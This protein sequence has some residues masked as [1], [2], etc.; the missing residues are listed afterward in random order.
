MY[1]FLVCFY[2]LDHCFWSHTDRYGMMHKDDLGGLLGIMTPDL[3][4]DGR[5]RD[6][7]VLGYW[8]S[9]FQKIPD[10]DSE[11]I[12][13]IDIFLDYYEKNFGF[14]FP[15][16]RPILKE[17]HVLAYVPTAKEKAKEACNLHNY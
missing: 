17:G 1:Y 5:P 15:L 8:N 13:T 14:D 6:E 10:S 16:A 3:L 11:W 4:A 7:T 9:V 2:V 12:D